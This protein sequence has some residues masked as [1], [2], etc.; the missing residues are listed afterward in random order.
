MSAKI[1]NLRN[2]RKKDFEIIKELSL[3]GVHIKRKVEREIS[4]VEE[5]AVLSLISK[6][7]DEEIEEKRNSD[8]CMR[9]DSE[10]IEMYNE[11]VFWELLAEKL[12]A[13]DMLEEFGSDINELNVEAYK[14]VK[15]D[16]R[17]R[18]L[19]SFKIPIVTECD[20][21]QIKEIIYD[22]NLLPF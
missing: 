5:K 14:R 12:A 6:C 22:N 16:Y 17:E 20:G 19:E 8:F 13:R 4:I 21:L 7:S 1:N 11:M 10:L 9:A 18:Y 15:N 2:L 3:L